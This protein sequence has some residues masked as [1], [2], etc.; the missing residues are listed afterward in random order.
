[1]NKEREF[2][3]GHSLPRE[4]GTAN[5]RNAREHTN[6]DTYNNNDKKNNRVRQTDARRRGWMDAVNGNHRYA[7]WPSG[8]RP[9]GS[10]TGVFI[11]NQGGRA[12]RDRACGGREAPRAPSARVKSPTVQKSGLF[13]RADTSAFRVDCICFRERWLPWPLLKYSLA[14]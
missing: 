7:N 1:M 6:V 2:Y 14:E 4:R 13:C 3:G 5:P 11:Y 12:G 8:T 9:V 10:W